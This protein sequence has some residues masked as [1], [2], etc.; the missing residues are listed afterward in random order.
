MLTA[1]SGEVV[2]DWTAMVSSPA[3]W[4]WTAQLYSSYWC[5]LACVLHLVARDT[6]LVSSHAWNALLNSVYVISLKEFIVYKKGLKCFKHSDSHYT[7]CCCHWHWCCVFRVPFTGSLVGRDQHCCLVTVQRFFF[8][9]LEFLQVKVSH[10][11]CEHLMYFKTVLMKIGH[12]LSVGWV[13][14]VTDWISDI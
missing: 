1:C 5:G 3:Q 2:K 4:N 12:F 9:C 7:V 14:S 10:S 11:I 6:G 8:I 13:F